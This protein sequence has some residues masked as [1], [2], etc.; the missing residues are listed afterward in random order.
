MLATVL[1]MTFPGAPSIFYGDE[2]ALPGK[3]DPDSRRVFPE[4][5]N[6]DVEVLKSHK[7]L[8][9]LRHKYPALRTG[10]YKTLFADRDVY[11]F[12]RILEDEEI[13]VAV[14]IGNEKASATFPVTELKTQPEKLEYGSGR[15]VWHNIPEQPSL[16]I[17]LPEC[18]SI[19]VA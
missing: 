17:T 14:N 10:T 19:I 3:K 4:P 1:L 5:E 7:E 6:W 11:V 9:A 16:E 13:I 2:V 15:L 12:V 18:S 8:I